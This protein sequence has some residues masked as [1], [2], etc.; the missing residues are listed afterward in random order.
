MHSFAVGVLKA[1]PDQ[2][3][4]RRCGSAHNTRR[5]TDFDVDR[6]YERLRGPLLGLLRRDG[7]SI[8]DDEWDAVWNAVCVNV[9]HRQRAIG[10]DFRGEPLNYLLASAKNELR[11]E[12]RRWRLQAV[13]LDVDGACEPVAGGPELHDDLD[14]RDKLRAA[15]AI[16]RN[17]LSPRERQAWALR[18]LCGVGYEEGAA[19]LGI[20]PKRFQKALMSARAK[21]AD[22]IHAVGD[23]SWCDSTKAVS[24]LRAYEQG[25]LPPNG[26]AMRE[27]R[28]HARICPACRRAMTA[29]RLLA[30]TPSPRPR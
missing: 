26:A 4:G 3:A 12:R 11:R 1:V 10:I 28:E 21:I 2:P 25:M 19:R 24:M 27:L 6:D 30:P 22:E 9:W 16:A 13:S 14:V 20:T 29:A 8:A 15:R 5:F 7:W 18:V 23:G 17:R